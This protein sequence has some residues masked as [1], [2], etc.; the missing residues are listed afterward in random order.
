MLR[1]HFPK[2]SYEIFLEVNDFTVKE[3]QNSSWKFPKIKTY[4]HQEEFEIFHH[5][6]TSSTLSVDK[7][8]LLVREVN[9]KNKSSEVSAVLSWIA[10]R[11]HRKSAF[12]FI[13]IT[14]V[15]FNWGSKRLLQLKSMEFWVAVLLHLWVPP[16]QFSVVG[17]QPW[18]HCLSSLSFYDLALEFSTA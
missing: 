2:P 3:R 13:I 9:R 14:I 17:T 5:S 18:T 10:L 6:F 1:D 11:D 15:F 8:V 12:N 4:I 16:V 7:A